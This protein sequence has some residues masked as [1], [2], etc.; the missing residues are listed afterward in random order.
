MCRGAGSR[1]KR[2]LE[3]GQIW[4]PFTSSHPRPAHPPKRWG[5]CRGDTKGSCW[6]WTLQQRPGGCTR[7]PGQTLQLSIAASAQAGPFWARSI[8]E[9]TQERPRAT[10]TQVLRWKQQAVSKDAQSPSGTR[11]AHWGQQEPLTP[12]KRSLTRDTAP[13]PPKGRA[14][15]CAGRGGRGAT[16]TRSA[17]GLGCLHRH[18]QEKA[19]QSETYTESVF[20]VFF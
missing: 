5:H 20:I 4:A 9:Q 19:V 12:T 11:R 16:G 6:S 2:T 3:G 17:P 1:S 15:A 8:P 14:A 13:S 7:V 18:K 10:P